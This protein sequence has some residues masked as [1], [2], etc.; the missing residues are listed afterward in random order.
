MNTS[1]LIVAG[2]KSGEKYGAGLVK[3]FRDQHPE[4]HFFGVGG[5][6]MFQAGVEL[7][8][9]IEEMSVGG[10]VE[11]LTHIPRLYRIFSRL[12][13]LAKIRKPKAAVLID[14]P[15]FNLRLAKKLLSLKIPVLY[16]VSPT[17]WAWRKSRLK[18][19][20]KYVS[21]MMLIFPFEEKIYQQKNIPHIYI[22]H[23][24]CETIEA[25]LPREKFFKKYGLDPNKQLVSLLP[26][27][28]KSEIK[29]HMPILTEAIKKICLIYPVQFVL[30]RADNLPKNLFDPYGNSLS[31]P[32]PILTNDH[33]SALTHSILAL[34]SCGTASLQAALL[35]TPHIAFYR[36][37]PLT[38]NVGIHFIKIKLYSIVNIL[39]NKSI[40]PELIQNRFTISETMQE[41]RELF[42]SKQ[43]RDR[44]KEEF[45][46]LAQIL[47]DKN[48]SENAARE[49]QILIEDSKT[50]KN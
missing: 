38:F 43:K 23:P 6:H 32:L 42:D 47:G 44:M 2:E 15:D 16:Y 4:T 25:G 27:S 34:I 45:K 20:K 24:L 46:H 35:G 33:S 19:I 31:F 48:A 5:R 8:A 13:K 3:C 12:T 30:L 41:F 17:V 49:L 36:V 22:G 18:T 7:A 10:A 40:I 29:Y 26:G 11:I 9:S 28:R 1:V 39:A 37:S 14:S 21:K 50:G